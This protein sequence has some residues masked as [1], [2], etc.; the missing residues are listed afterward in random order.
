MTTTVSRTAEG[1][2]TNILEYSFTVDTLRLSCDILQKEDNGREK[3]APRFVELHQR[4][5]G[6]I[7]PSV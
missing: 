3:E 1:H 4:F 7:S 2:R 5:L 6:E